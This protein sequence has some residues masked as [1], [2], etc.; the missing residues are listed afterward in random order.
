VPQ[1][2]ASYAEVLDR[3][4]ATGATLVVANVPDIT[5]V[6][7][8]TSAEK[9]AAEVGLPLSVI[10]PLLGIGPGGFVAPD[11]F[12]LIQKILSGQMAGPLPGN[13]VLDVGEVATIRATV[14]QYNAFIALQAQAHGAG[15]VDVHALTNELRDHGFV[16]HGQRLTTD[17]L[18][19]LFSLDGTH[20]SNTGY[21]LFANEFIRALNTN[22]AAGIP[23]ANIEKI[24]SADPLVPAG[25]GHP[26]SAL[27]HIN[28]ETVESLRAV[29]AH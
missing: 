7:F 14:D 27:G 16:A 25:V 22:F 13:L 2:Q 1:F 12:P 20:P 5:V 19:G 3:L 18:G 4:A 24:A 28:H 15:L 29:M 9:V 17:F 11:A 26:A 6:P 21:G 8:L 10:G 23:A